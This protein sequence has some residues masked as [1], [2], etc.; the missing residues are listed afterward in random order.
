MLIDWHSISFIVYLL[1]NYGVAEEKIFIG[2]NNFYHID[3]KINNYTKPYNESLAYLALDMAAASYAKNPRKCLKKLEGKLKAHWRS[4]CDYVHDEC[5]GFIGIVKDY[6][7]FSIRGTRTKLQLIMELIETM[8]RPK[9]SFIAG[10]AVEAYFYTAL[11]TFWTN[12]SRVLIKLKTKYPKKKILFTGHSLGGAV[13]SLASALFVYENENV[14]GKSLRNETTL[15]TFGQPR[16]GNYMYSIQ[17]DT[18]VPN[19]WRLIHK[20]DL[21]PHIP[22]C[23]EYG[24]KRSCI[25]A[26]NHS[27]YHHGT[28]VWYPISM[29]GTSNYTICLG[30]PI[31][32][33]DTCSNKCFLH[34][35]INDHLRY[36]EHDVSSY[37]D[38]GCVDEVPIK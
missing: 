21:V 36:F 23:Y 22:A 11:K 2:N 29:N 26:F 27:P 24:R 35:D 31:N 12:S 9:Q 5:W 3:E 28:E 1:F 4:K 6:I 18:L 14:F 7:I 32:E 8:S 30:E 10:G 33:D 25:P 13:A 34:Y 37:G 15:I 19:S 16:V 38:N 17:H 20:F